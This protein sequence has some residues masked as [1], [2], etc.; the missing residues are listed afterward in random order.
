[1]TTAPVPA[2]REFRRTV[3]VL[4]LFGIVFGYVEA[5]AVTY[6]R[7]GYQPIHQRLHPDTAPDDLFPLITLDQWAHEGHPYVQQ[8]LLEVAREVGTLLVVALVAAGGARDVRQ[9]FAGFVLAFGVWDVFYYLW[10]AVLIGWPRSLLDWDLVFA[11]P[12]PW[13]SPVLA[14]LLVAVTMVAAGVVFLWREASGR[15]VRPRPVHW[16]A[17]L[18]GGLVAVVAF[19]W[20]WRNTLEGGVPNTF[21]WPLFALG[22]GLGVVGYL[23]ALVT[24]RSAN[25]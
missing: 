23:H 8:P 14:P 5:A 2:W 9:W 25:R 16:A 6:V 21:N 11:F 13:A 24:S 22:L 17:V 12:V 1:V 15:P 4:V 3:S 20:D 7:V 18:G 10:L 19:W